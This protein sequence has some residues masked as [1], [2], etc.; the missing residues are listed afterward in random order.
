MK[1]VV[2]SS[3]NELIKR[4]RRKMAIKRTVI[5]TIL[6]VSIVTILCLKLEYFNIKNLKVTNNKVV[7]SEE[8][9]GLAQVNVG[10]NIFY[11]DIKKIRTNVLNNPYIIKAEVKRSIPNTINITVKE[12]EAAFYVSFQDKYFIIDRNGIVLEERMDISGMKLTRLEGF[13]LDGAQT[14]KTV[15]SASSRKLEN[16]ALITEL[17][18][19]NT[20]GIN[21]TAV[22]LTDDLNVKIYCN[23]LY[24]KVGGTSIKERL[25]QAFNIIIE[26]NLKNKKGY[27]DVS[28][29]GKPVLRF[30]N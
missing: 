5:L 25:N 19:L 29:D 28:S 2:A 8:I 3:S 22:D 18:S 21:I 10:T 15:P 16:I 7:S 24:V 9:I 27:I 14:G 30:D 1:S 11:T 13:N 4:R 12:R 6:L 17:I 26:N 23:D 20:S